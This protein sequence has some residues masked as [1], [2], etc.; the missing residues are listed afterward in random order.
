MP[1]GR[2]PTLDGALVGSFGRL[3]RTGSGSRSSLEGLQSVVRVLPQGARVADRER[4]DGTMRVKPGQVWLEEQDEHLSV[5][6]LVVELVDEGRLELSDDEG[7][8]V[9]M[10]G[11][12]V[13][14]SGVVL[15]A[16]GAA[17][18]HGE[19]V[20]GTVECMGWVRWMEDGGIPWPDPDEETAG[21]LC[22]FTRLL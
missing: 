2:P 6:W 5:T 12:N 20:K 10:D 11:A 8:R 13:T 17:Y 1:G 4:Y 18:P 21:I 22:R 3:P 19:E 9:V 15:H 7:R 16:E 14:V